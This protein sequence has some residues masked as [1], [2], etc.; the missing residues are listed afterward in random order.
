MDNLTSAQRRLCMTR[1]RSTNTK[2]EILFRKYLWS[3]GFR[4]YRVKSKLE[5]KPDLY[6]PKKQ[7]E[8]LLT[9]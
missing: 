5:G 7:T 4:G 9:L 8:H 1:I 2:I 6:F 3:N